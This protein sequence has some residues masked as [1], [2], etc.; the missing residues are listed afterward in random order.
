MDGTKREVLRARPVDPA[1]A[2]ATVRRLEE[3]AVAE[4]DSVTAGRPEEHLVGL[5]DRMEGAMG[6]WGEV[7]PFSPA[8]GVVPL[9]AHG[10]FEA[11]EGRAR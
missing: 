1:G 7:A 6:R 9:A 11:L 5:L 3:R 4:G 2:E 8:A 10:G